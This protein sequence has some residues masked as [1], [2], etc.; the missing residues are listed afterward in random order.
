MVLIGN[1]LRLKRL[2]LIDDVGD[3]AKFVLM[4]T[5][6]DA[7]MA[8]FAR[9]A[10]KMCY[11]LLFQVFFTGILRVRTT[12]SWFP[13]VILSLG[14]SS[15]LVIPSLSLN[16]GGGTQTLLFALTANGCFMW[17]FSVLNERDQRKLWALN[18]IREAEAFWQQ[19]FIQL[20]FP[21]VGR[22]DDGWMEPAAAIQTSFGVD[23][24]NTADLLCLRDGGDYQPEIVAFVNEVEA[25]GAPAKRN[26]MILPRGSD[27]LFDC[28]V[29]ACLEINSQR[30]KATILGFE[31]RESFPAVAFDFDFGFDEPTD[32]DSNRTG[33]DFAAPDAMRV[34]PSSVSDANQ[35]FTNETSAG[36]VE[37]RSAPGGLGRRAASTSRKFTDR[38]AI[39][40][41]A[42]RAADYPAAGPAVWGTDFRTT[43]ATFIR[44]AR[45]CLRSPRRNSSLRRFACSSSAGI[46]TSITCWVSR[47]SRMARCWSWSMFGAR[48]PQH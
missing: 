34:L 36:L 29:C 15:L 39:P 40:P 8:I 46:R 17:I 12:I 10:Q 37:S 24:H 1:E 28:S 48:S 16:D 31:I 5:K 11:A 7:D 33:I 18:Q 44:A 30:R 26:F 4:L 23:V 6:C 45:A 47:A 43:P 21:V 27:I 25:T 9:D 20:V 19:E 2:S 22:V 32:E 41:S 14:F 42:L 38:I 3:K 13:P 35:S